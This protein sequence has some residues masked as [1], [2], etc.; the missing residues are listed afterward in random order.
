M[1]L[2]NIHKSI[3]EKRLAPLYLLYGKE[4]FLI[5]ET[6]QKIIDAILSEEELEFN[7]SSFVRQLLIADLEG[8]VN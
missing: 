2:A 6:K 8:S 1:S 4:T 3:Q 7:L 5:D